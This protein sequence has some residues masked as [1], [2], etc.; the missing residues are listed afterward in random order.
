V[1][2]WLIGLTKQ[3]SY[4]A[5]RAILR[6][7]QELKELRA[8]RNSIFLSMLI[9]VIGWGVQN[10]TLSLLA[11]AVGIHAPWY[12][13]A[14]AVPFSLI[15]TMAP[16]AL[17]GYGLREGILVAILLKA[18]LTAA[19]AAAVTLLVDLQMVPFI[20]FSALLWLR[21]DIIPTSKAVAEN[22]HDIKER[23]ISGRG[24]TAIRR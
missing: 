17:N 9:S 8:N 11:R 1:A 22:A 13:F 15:A 18:G 12:L 3:M 19:N 16:F 10:Y 2:L 7:A 24:Q 23:S 14:M 6:L 21:S 4:R 20:A 5:P